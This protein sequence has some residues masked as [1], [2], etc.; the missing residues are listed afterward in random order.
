MSSQETLLARVAFK[1]DGQPAGSQS[2][3]QLLE[4]IVV[5]IEGGA[6]GGSLTAASFEAFMAGLPVG[7]PGIPGK[8]YNN[9][10]IPSISQP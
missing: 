1:L 10:G 2:E 4:R 9:G 7:D 5:A 3:E 6:V 8:A